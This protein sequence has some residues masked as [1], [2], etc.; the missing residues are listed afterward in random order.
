VSCAGPACAALTE[1][2]FLDELPVVL[3][4]SRLS[5]PVNE[6]PAAVTVI[7]QDM[8]RA[9]GFRD[10]PD[11]LRLVPGFSVAYTRDNTWAIGYHGMADAFSRRFQVLVDGRSIYSA[12]YGA[13]QWQ[14]LPLA[15]DD[16]ERIE[17]VRG[18]NAATHGA[19]AFLAVINII[20]KD[21]SQ[22]PGSFASMQLGEQGMAGLT[23][24]HGG[25][26]GDLRY[27]LTFSA[28]ARDRFETRATTVSLFEETRTYL[29][30]GRAD[31]RVSATD[32]ISAQF[33]VSVGDWEAGYSSSP[34][35][36]RFQDVSAQ[37]AQF[38]YRRVRS[39]DDE[40]MV[41]A[42]FSRNNHDAPNIYNMGGGLLLDAGIDLLQTRSNLE[43]QATRRFAP[44]W[45]AVW[46]AEVR[47]ETVQSRR[48]FN[49]GD[50]LDGTLVRAYANLEWRTRPD[51]LV[52]GGAMLEHHYFTGIDVSPR[53]AM[54]Y[55][56]AEG[57][58]LRFNVSRAYRSP[59]FFEQQGDWRYYSTGGAQLLHVFAP[60]AHLQPERI[61]SREVGYIG[62]YPALRLT[63]DAK[64]FHDTIDRFI[65]E[66][67][68]MPR[69]FTN[70]DAYTVRGG[71]LQLAWRP[72]PRLHVAAQY[73]R[74]FIHAD[75]SI[76]DDLEDSAPRDVFSLLARYEL[77]QGWQA[78][79]GL[80]YS[81][82]MKWLSDGDD[83]A[84]FTRWD[85]RLA[86]R[87][88]WQ[89]H[90]LEAAVVGQSLGGDYS[91]FRDANVFSQRVYGSL[92]LA[93]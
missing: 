69:R 52:H 1:A 29:L 86:R 80:Y 5:Q 13:V 43:F 61:L 12:A 71:D 42:Y 28:Q 63:L 84:S 9:S 56:L 67:G 53:L 45:R 17:V 55:A 40:W 7:D 78:S 68:P 70:R 41:Q 31:Y 50:T 19:N 18:P 59:T 65:K 36:P 49:R 66:S 22:T 15:I 75:P 14:E 24:R 74:A 4:V 25:A 88:I 47:H 39:A 32:E 89:G 3:S 73:A 37:Y 87:W 11:L 27:R 83:N 16:V 81:G 6:A 30:N 64:L 60:S 48:Y 62:Q 35:E 23:L 54:N 76:D 57:H 79:T 10:I 21:P 92:S 58:T 82:Y 38:K 34:E 44:A 51:L 26:G 90:D 85:V 46:G 33:G 2:D 20:T 72:S 91:E 93:W 77:G 8:I